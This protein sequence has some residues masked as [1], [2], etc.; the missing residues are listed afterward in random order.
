MANKF[1]EVILKNFI[2]HSKDRSGIHRSD[3]IC[4]PHKPFNRMVLGIP[5]IFSS[6]T[7]GVFLV[8]ELSHLLLHKNFSAQEY[9]IMVANLV[10]MHI[11]AI[12]STGD[13]QNLIGIED[14]GVDAKRP[15]ESKTTRKFIHSRE[16]IPNEWLEQLAFG[17]SYLGVEVGYIMVENLL[18]GIPVMVIKITMNAQERDMYKDAFLWKI[19]IISNFLLTKDDSNL[20]VHRYE[21][22]HCEYK[23]CKKR[24]EQYPENEGCK[25]Y[26]PYPEKPRKKKEDN[27]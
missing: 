2:E 12:A 22:K 27:E 20:E 13:F 9:E 18:A 24:R 14:W 7:I 3:I 23:P 5:A 21:C 11:D 19:N 17:M 15:L 6:E 26:N 10:S 4:C 8:G 25:F 16:D 1:T